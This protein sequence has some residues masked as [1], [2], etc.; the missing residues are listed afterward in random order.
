MKK[1][2]NTVDDLMMLWGWEKKTST[3][4]NKYGKFT[5]IR[6]EAE[7]AWLNGLDAD[8]TP[9][10]QITQNTEYREWYRVWIEC[11]INC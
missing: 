9:Y 4:S 2:G 1:G 6:V 10:S 7:K 8:A 11:N 3:Q 5:Q